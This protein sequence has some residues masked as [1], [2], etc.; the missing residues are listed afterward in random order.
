MRI[1][2]LI[3]LVGGLVVFCS[4]AM[5]SGA[6]KD[7]DPG[8]GLY[9][10][11]KVLPKNSSGELVNRI[12]IDEFE[13]ALGVGCG[14]CHA[15]MPGSEKLDYASDAKP[16]KEIARTMMRMTL[17]LNK[18]Y[19]MVPKPSIGDPALIVSCQTCHRGNAHP[20]NGEGAAK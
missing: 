20:E 10:N 15:S 3:A 2:C 18:K 4:F 1:L 12:M 7:H 5:V 16:E 14:F 6:A 19:F 17:R 8:P 9:K 13:D 11:L